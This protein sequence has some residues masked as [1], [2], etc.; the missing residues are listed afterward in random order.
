MRSN[1]QN[2]VRNSELISKLFVLPL[3]GS[4]DEGAHYQQQSVRLFL[5][6][7]CKVAKQLI[8]SLKYVQHPILLHKRTEFDLIAHTDVLRSCAVKTS[9]ANPSIV[10]VHIEHQL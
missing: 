3:I 1:P 5:Q 7:H 2:S 8:D 6:G 10:V 4:G 9:R